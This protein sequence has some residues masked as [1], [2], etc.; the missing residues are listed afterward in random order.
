M[1]RPQT[2]SDEEFDGEE[3]LSF[4]ILDPGPLPIAS[5]MSPLELMALYT[6]ASAHDVSIFL[7]VVLSLQF[8]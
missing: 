3:A 5:S 6:A 4:D 7:V 8:L 1:G 2:P